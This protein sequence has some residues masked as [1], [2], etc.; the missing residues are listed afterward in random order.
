MNRVRVFQFS[1][2]VRLCWHQLGLSLECAPVAHLCLA[3]WAAGNKV[4]PLF[5]K[6]NFEFVLVWV[7]LGLQSV[8]CVCSCSIHEV[9]GLMGNQ[10]ILKP[11]FERT[12]DYQSTLIALRISTGTGTETHPCVTTLWWGLW[13]D[14][15]DVRGLSR[16]FTSVM[17]ALS[18][19]T[20]FHEIQIHT[21]PFLLFVSNDEVENFCC[22]QT[23]LYS[24]GFPPDSGAGPL[25][26]W[27]G[28]HAADETAA[29]ILYR[30]GTGRQ[31]LDMTHTH[32]LH[33]V[34]LACVCTNESVVNDFW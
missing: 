14:V 10:T 8:F 21:Q 2:V 15:Q 12:A 11:V 24:F 5:C 33:S 26:R 22:R 18:R 28:W 7:C 3:V 1:D 4:P 9:F 27:K 6:M 16:L 13:M 34:G 20:V 23:W 25:A 29:R 30:A 31:S 17:D 32:C 19:P